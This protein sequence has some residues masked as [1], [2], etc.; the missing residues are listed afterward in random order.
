M[1]ETCETDC[2]CPCGWVKVQEWTKAQIESKVKAIQEKLKIDKTKLSATVGIKL[3]TY[4]S[5]YI[6]HELCTD[7]ASVQS[8][9]PKV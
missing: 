1:E 4:G 8:V 3:Y 2:F 7:H 9:T 6:Y 5:C